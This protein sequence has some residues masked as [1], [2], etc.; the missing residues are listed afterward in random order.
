VLK[1][2]FLSSLLLMLLCGAS[3]CSQKTPEKPAI[4]A[5]KLAYH[6]KP[7][8]SIRMVYSVR[9]SSELKK[10]EI[11]VLFVIDSV[12]HN[13]Y[14]FHGTLQHMGYD[15]PESEL[16]LG[17]NQDYK[18]LEGATHSFEMTPQGVFVSDVSPSATLPYEIKSFFPELP[19]TELRKGS[20]WSTVSAQ[21]K[22]IINKI[23]CDYTVD[24]INDNERMV[25]TS[26]V[27]YIDDTGMFS[28]SGTGIYAIDTDTGLLAKSEITFDSKTP[29]G[30]LK[31]VYT[32]IRL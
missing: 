10:L 21:E 3:A 24:H 28:K 15:K 9:K 11:S 8:D 23:V 16:E 29:V 25:A 20:T 14:F 27:K 12:A 13:N 6:L 17:M 7:H 22:G 32:L 31:H 30:V 5:V 26:K 18:A 19:S 2:L 4:T 1:Q